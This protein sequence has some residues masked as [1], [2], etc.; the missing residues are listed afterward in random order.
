MPVIVDYEDIKNNLNIC[1]KQS[2]IFPK[3][4]PFYFLESTRELTFNGY[5]FFFSYFSPFYQKMTV[6]YTLVATTVKTTF[7]QA[8]IH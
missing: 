6:T 2:F 4:L 8:F 1:G 5:F 7:I 3:K